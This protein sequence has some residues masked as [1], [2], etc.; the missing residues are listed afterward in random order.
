MREIWKALCLIFLAAAIAAPTLPAS[1]NE[2]CEIM[3][4]LVPNQVRLNLERFS[5]DV[6][7]K[8]TDLWTEDDFRNLAAN[9]EVC[10]GTVSETNPSVPVDPAVWARHLNAAASKVLP[11]SAMTHAARN[12]RKQD[13]SW[14]EVPGCMSVLTWK[15]D[16]V[17]NDDNSSEI[18]GLDLKDMTTHQRKTVRAFT[19]DCLPVMKEILEIYGKSA[20]TAELIAED[21]V[22]SA[23]REDLA[24]SENV[25]MISPSLRVTRNGRRIPLAYLS[26]STM[27]A[28]EIANRYEISGTTMPADELVRLSRWSEKMAK[29][30]KD[31]P[32]AAY[33]EAVRKIVGK[34]LFGGN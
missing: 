19:T 5:A 28:V 14:G 8:P 21:I 27:E 9:A 34:H 7:G 12:N 13:W 15:R 17:W 24:A 29:E 11:I 6:L 26:A 1:A 2:N 3:A 30:T 33:A 25:S 32:D 20:S 16:P 18:F 23:E 22:R 31:G 4:S 10:R